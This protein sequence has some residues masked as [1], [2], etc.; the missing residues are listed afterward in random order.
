MKTLPNN[1]YTCPTMADMTID[2]RG[3]KELLM[4]TGGSILARGV[5]WDIKT[6]NMGAGVYRVSLKRKKYDG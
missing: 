6:K 4:A 3:L 2:S 5:L 1:F